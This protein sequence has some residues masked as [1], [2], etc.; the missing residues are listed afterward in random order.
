MQFN[1]K[2]VVASLPEVLEPNALYFVRAEEGFDLYC[3]DVTGEIAHKINRSALDW[4]LT[5]IKTSNYDAQDR[6]KIPCSTANGSFTVTLPTHGMVQIFDIGNTFA[7]SPLYIAAQQGQ[8]VA[9]YSSIEVDLGGV[10]LELVYLDGDWKLAQSTG[11]I[12]SLQEQLLTQGTG[13]RIDVLGLE[14]DRYNYDDEVAGFIFY[15]E[16]T[17]NLYV[18][19]EGGG[20]WSDPIPFRGAKGETGA[21]GTS[22]SI[23][24]KDAILPV[25]E[26]LNFIGNAVEVN[27]NVELDSTDVSINLPDAGAGLNLGTW[28]NSEEFTA[29]ISFNNENSKLIIPSS[30]TENRIN[31]K[32]LSGEIVYDSEEETIFFGN[33][34]E[35]GGIPLRSLPPV[36]SNEISGDRTLI[37]NQNNSISWSKFPGKEKLFEDK[38]IWVRLDGDDE[39]DGS[40]NLSQKAVRTIQKA[41]QLANSYDFNTHKI[42][43][44]FFEEY[45]I[46]QINVPAISGDGQLIFD[47]N[48]SGILRLNTNN[49]SEA[50]FYLN[51]SRATL[52]NLMLIN[53]NSIAPISC[54]ICVNNL[55]QVQISNITFGG[56]NKNNDISCHILIKNNSLM[57]IDNVQY[58][59]VGGARNHYRLENNS[60]LINKNKNISLEEN[61]SFEEFAYV[62]NNSTLVDNGLN[63]ISGNLAG[64]S[65]YLCEYGS[66]I[67]QKNSSF[68]ASLEGIIR[69]GGQVYS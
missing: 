21:P 43:I 51:G 28:D 22:Y 65:K 42:T 35:Y 50:N 5:N 60:L 1:I 69:M 52:K 55:S 36:N 11:K 15:A 18:K 38:V 12:I 39:N 37:L 14:E 19:R 6:E 24:H 41:I 63:N 49:V 7:F 4:D 34:N 59:I 48:N 40:E 44:S 27:D 2:K 9:G 56:V 68:P 10:S 20:G 23:F 29:G 25:R 64:G 17:G 66:L 47:G 54:C 3:S 30:T 58:S 62:T 45:N 26:K 57:E 31:N 16:D 46:N 33:N 53:D 67:Q 13:F 8:T 32:L 61:L